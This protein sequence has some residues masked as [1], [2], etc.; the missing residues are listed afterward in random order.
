MW[1]L[2]Q[3]VCP[4]VNVTDANIIILKPTCTPESQ[5][6]T[7]FIYLLFPNRSL[8]RKLQR[9]RLAKSRTL[10]S[11]PQSPTVS[12]VH[13]SDLIGG[14]PPHR[15]KLP[16]GSGHPKACTLP[17]AGK[18]KL[19]T[20]IQCFF[21]CFVNVC[22]PQLQDATGESTATP[23]FLYLFICIRNVSGLINPRINSPQIIPRMHLHWVC[24]APIIFTVKMSYV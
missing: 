17:S 4:S 11:I 19:K 20:T 2:F 14:S 5:S 16:S 15:T 24:S 6:S 13:Q 18:E 21:N 7:G 23:L 8:E 9:P 3:S 22:L 12:R 1:E 10:P